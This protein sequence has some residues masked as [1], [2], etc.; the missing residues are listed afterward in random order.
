MANTTQD[1]IDRI[2]AGLVALFGN[3]IN[4][5][6]NEPI[7]QMISLF[8]NSDTLLYQLSEAVRAQFNLSKSAGVNLD[9]LAKLFL[10]ARQEAT[11]ST[12]SGVLMIG[13]A[14]TVIDVGS[15]I[16][17]LNSDILTDTF[18]L[19]TEVVLNVSGE[20]SGTFSNDIDGA[21]TI[22]TGEPFVILTQVQ[23]WDSVD[24]SGAT[25]VVG[26]D[27]QND[28]NLRN[29]LQYESSK[30]GTNLV[31][32]LSGDLLNLSIITKSL[33]Y[34]YKTDTTNPIYQVTPNFT[35]GFFE[36][37]VVIS[38]SL[39]DQDNYDTV[40]Q[41]VWNHKPPA[42]VPESEQTNQG[43]PTLDVDGTA[44]DVLGNEHTVNFSLAL[45][46]S[47]SADIDITPISN[48]AFDFDAI[49]ADIKTALA[50]YINDLLIADLA[51]Y[52]LAFCVIV[53]AN[54]DY[55]YSV[56]SFTWTDVNN[57]A[58]TTDIQIPSR[59]YGSLLESNIT[60]TQV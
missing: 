22:N 4:T 8:A 19:T 24:P 7:G 44:Y 52:S 50:A 58:V 5:N 36:P 6:P 56:Q 20:G 10:A 25:V 33:V 32:T 27:Y 2:T 42:I 40:A 12:M 47:F 35:L 45:E 15:Q 29:D 13:T 9:I 49:E 54:S 59:S 18:S 39:P 16:G 21:R 60:V 38:S 28:P 34:E 48:Q 46:D 31:D 1:I 3:D 30:N 53:S 23:G 11:P 43:E 57:T 41:I 17:Y 37:I 55:A 26:E 51:I 14:S